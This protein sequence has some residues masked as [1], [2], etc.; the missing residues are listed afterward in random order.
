MI[1]YLPLYTQIDLRNVLTNNTPCFIKQKLY[2]PP[3]FT[4]TMKI[5]EPQYQPSL[6]S[7]ITT[8]FYVGV[9]HTVLGNPTTNTIV[10]L[11]PEPLYYH[12]ALTSYIDFHNS[13]PIGLYRQ[14]HW[15]YYHITCSH[16][17]NLVVRLI[18]SSC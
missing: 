12:V 18:K 6:D 10:L 13:R 14:I 11:S 2:K 1:P 17:F 15:L 4:S 9:N 5:I 8:K 3:H 7:N 16:R